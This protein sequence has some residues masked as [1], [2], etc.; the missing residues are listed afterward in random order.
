MTKVVPLNPTAHGKL[1]VKGLANLQASLGQQILPLVVHE[2]P[3]AGNDCP[4]VFV[5]LAENDQF[6]AVQ[7]L[8]LAE[9]E[10]LMV[11]GDRWQGGYIPFILRGAPFRLMKTSADA[12]QVTIGIDEDSPL[13]SEEEGEALFNADG[14]PTSYLEQRRDDLQRYV[15]HG[16][17]TQ[18]FVARLVEL[19]LLVPQELNIELA[20]Q[21]SNITGIYLVSEQKLRELDDEAVLDLNKR[22]FLLAIHA[23][24]M[25]LGQ[26]RRLAQLKLEAADDS[27]AQVRG[28]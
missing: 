17:V 6:Q 26:A 12:D 1:R 19:D 25:S 27:G 24:L 8:G 20:G 16:Q 4:V 15:H 5:K 2:F 11:D 13:L 21:K 23:H 3:Q 14:T 7:L 18:A 28:A 10:N 9:G 22:G